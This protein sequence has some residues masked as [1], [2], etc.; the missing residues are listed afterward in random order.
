MTT[1]NQAPPTAFELVGLGA[2]QIGGTGGGSGQGGYG[3]GLTTDAVNQVIAGPATALANPAGVSTFSDVI[4]MVENYLKTMPLQTLQLFQYFLPGTTTADFVD[5]PTAVTT[6]INAL[7]LGKLS[8]TSADTARLLNDLTILLDVFHLTYNA[9]TSTDPPGTLGVGGVGPGKPTWYSAWNDVLAYIS[10]VTGVTL[11]APAPTIGPAITAAGTGAFTAQAWATRLT[12]DL[13]VTSDVFHLVYHTGTPTDAPGL[14]YT[15]GGLGNG[16]MTW[17]GAWNDLLAL[18]GVVNAVTPPTDPAPA[19]GAAITTAQTAASTAQSGATAANGNA[20]AALTQLTAIPAQTVVPDLLA[21]ASSVTFDHAGSGG[22]ATNPSGSV[23]S[24]L[25]ATGT[26]DVGASASAMVAAVTFSFVGSGA[27]GSAQVTVGSQNMQSLGIVQLSSVTEYVEFFVLWTPTVGSGQPVTATAYNFS[28][29]VGSIS[30]ESATYIG[31]TNVSN[32]LV[33]SSGTGTSLSLSVPAAI[34][35][36][37]AVVAFS[38]G[39]V[40]TLAS[41]A[42]SAYTKTQRGSTTVQVD[43][44][45]YGYQSL[46]FG[47]ATGGSG[48]V[49][50]GATGADSFAE[51]VG[52]GVVLSATSVI[53][54]G[55]RAHST[56]ST[57]ASV[58]GNGTFGPYLGVLDKV[59]ADYYF[60]SSTGVLTVKNAG[61]YQVKIAFLTGS[62]TG[63]LLGPVLYQNGAVVDAGLRIAPS[64]S[65]LILADSFT[66]YCSANDTLQPGYFAGV[67]YAAAFGADSTATASYWEVSLLNRSLL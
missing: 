8:S 65:S 25:S 13:T 44:G 29:G 10:K 64:T 1:P 48:G 45:Q 3:Q 30:F 6:I 39:D 26:Q 15:G 56:N 20:T 52:V 66:V 41:T 51:W 27:V 18:C 47:D 12:N 61:W 43:A 19:V 59:T 42:L 53:G 17:Y 62:Y 60:N 11:A 67:S 37:M 58:A 16:K 21:G 57:G 4:T 55:F 54:S 24:P 9:G 50:F 2:F 22:S 23:S 46:A 36:T 49:T 14:I 63:A 40:A 28:G 32:A 5:V 33:T 35:G 38:A 31:A 7:G 34:A